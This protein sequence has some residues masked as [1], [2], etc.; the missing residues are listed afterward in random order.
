MTIVIPHILNPIIS[1]NIGLRGE[2]VSVV[3]VVVV[4]VDDVVEVTATSMT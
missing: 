1:V 4:V 3:V 2:T